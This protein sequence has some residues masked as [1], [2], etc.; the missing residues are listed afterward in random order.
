[1]RVAVAEREKGDQDQRDPFRRTPGERDRQTERNDRQRDA[2]LDAGQRQADHAGDAAD[3]H[4]QR[5][6]DRQRPYRP[7]AHLRAPQAD[8]EHR[9]KMIRPGQRMRKAAAETAL[10]ALDDMRG[11]CFRETG[12]PDQEGCAGHR[13]RPAFACVA[14]RCHSRQKSAALAPPIIPQ[15]G[16]AVVAAE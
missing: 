16:L 4:D 12:E 2:D 13:A 1:M 8:R 10:R 6:G 7:S 9:E 15:R 14:I 11:G 5:K 3:H